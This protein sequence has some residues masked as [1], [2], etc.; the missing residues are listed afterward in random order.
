[1]NTS[2][3]KYENHLNLKEL[4]RADRNADREN[5]EQLVICFDLQKV[6][7]VPQSFVNNFYYKRKINIYNLTAH[8]SIDKKGYCAVWDE[9]TCGRSAND[10]AS[11]L[12]LILEKIVSKHSNVESLI[13]WSDS[14]ISQNKN[15]IISYALINFI[16]IDQQINQILMKFSVPGHGCVQEVDNIHSL[17]EKT[18]RKSEVFSL[19]TIARLIENSNRKNSYNVIKMEKENFKDFQS[20]S[21]IFNFQQIP[22][23]KIFQ[24]RFTRSYFEINYRLSPDSDFINVNIREYRRSFRNSSNTARN[25]IPDPKINRAKNIISQ[26]KKKDII[27]MMPWAPEVDKNYLKSFCN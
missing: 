14:C 5:K 24:I 13:L 27:S 9:K 15:S 6:I 18:L 17:I 21:K 12:Y 16:K 23:S 7:T 26:E 4:V 19:N 11:S 20:C 10:I 25:E 1:M 8:D 22:F 2:D 3:E